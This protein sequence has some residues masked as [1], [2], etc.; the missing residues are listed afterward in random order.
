MTA[1][2]SCEALRDDLIAL[3][4]DDG[5]IA[6]KARARDHLAQCVPCR[7]EYSELKGIRKALGGWGLPVP[8]PLPKPSPNR[9]FLAPGLA[10]AAG[11]VL[12]IGIA[13]AGRSVL[14][15]PPP[16]SAA[17]ATSPEASPQFVSFDQLQEALKTQESRH[18]ADIAD[19]RRTLTTVSEAPAGARSPGPL[20]NVAN[21]SPAT[22]ERLLKASEERQA[23]LI[24]A[25]LAGLRTESDLQRQ[26]DM[27]QI[28]A[29]LAY[30]DSRTGA[31]AARTSELM[32]NLVRVTAK[33]QDR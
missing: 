1:T 19:L 4:Y 25:R 14:A 7:A 3:L 26:Y 15:P 18:Q 32:K 5:D 9:R 17:S 20:T 16:A 11:L 2:L 31:D 6:D 10:A 29:G 28:A 21:L 22:I 8:A 13:V 23:R 27:A 30:I 24:E 33:P 12:G